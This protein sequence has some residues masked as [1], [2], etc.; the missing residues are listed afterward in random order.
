MYTFKIPQRLS[1]DVCLAFFTLYSSIQIAGGRITDNVTPKV[2]HDN[3]LTWYMPSEV[4]L[5]VVFG[6]GF[7]CGIVF[8]IL[9]DCCKKINGRFPW[10]KGEYHLGHAR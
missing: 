7:A 9:C 1:F 4:I 8:M 3:N 2:I 6:S 10:T 5:C